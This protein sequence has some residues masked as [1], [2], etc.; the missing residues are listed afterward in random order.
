MGGWGWGWGWLGGGC[1]R[2]VVGVVTGVGGAGAGGVGSSVG[3][4]GV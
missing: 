1:R 4:D 2:L 3:V